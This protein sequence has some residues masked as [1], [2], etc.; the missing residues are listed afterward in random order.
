MRKIMIVDDEPVMLNLASRI[1]SKEYETVCASSGAEALQLFVK[2]RPDLVLSDLLMP[3][4]DGYELHRLLQEYGDEPVPVIFMTADERDTSESKVFE[5]GAAD[6]IHKPVKADVLLRRIGNIIQNLDRIHGLKKKASLDALTGLLNKGAAQREIAELCVRV[7]GTLLM[8][9]LDSFKLINDI[10]G[11]GMG[12]RILIRFADLLRHIIRAADPVGRIGGDEFIVYLQHLKDEAII[13]DKANYLNRE[14]QRSAREFMGE[15]MAIPLGA[16]VG[17]VFVPEEGTAFSEL[18]EKADQALYTV[19]Q[20]GKHGFAAYGTS[21]LAPEHAAPKSISQIQQILGERN[22]DAGAYYVDFE[23][24]QGIYRFLVRFAGREQRSIQ[25]VQVSLHL[26]ER[27][28]EDMA[29]QQ[30]QEMLIRSLRRSD[31]VTRHGKGQFL[32]LLLDAKTEDKESIAAR[33]QANW[34]DFSASA[35]GTIS[36]E[37][38]KIAAVE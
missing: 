14:L 26:Q 32:M 34:K 22:V 3:E 33:L 25:I 37:M 16:S 20:H 10:Y 30:L 18:C 1:L 13:R 28:D 6:Y 7:P 27:A 2:E 24:F 21:H 38:E 36:L 17:A 23:R 5:A 4:M 12:D 9:D 31:C 15:D 29:L 35:D 11:H 19:K 8:I